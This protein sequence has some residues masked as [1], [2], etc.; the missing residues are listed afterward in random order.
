MEL[1][2]ASVSVVSYYPPEE[3]GGEPRASLRM[4]NALPA[5]YDAFAGGNRW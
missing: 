3:E 1:T 2:P 5:E 4:F